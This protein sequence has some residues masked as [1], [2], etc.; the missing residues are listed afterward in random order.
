MNSDAAGTKALVSRLSAAKKAEDLFGAIAP[1]PT[2]ERLLA[3]KHLFASFVVLI[4]P[5][6]NP[7]LEDAGQHMARL[8]ALRMEADAL[9]REGTYGTHRKAVI[10]ATLR[11]P[12][13]V[14][15]VIDE[16]REGEVA[17]LFVAENAGK[18]CLLKVVREPGDNDLLDVEART[19]TELHRSADAKAPV[20]RKY[21]P[22]LLDSFVIIEGGRVR[23]RVNVLD[24]AEPQVEYLRIHK[25]KKGIDAPTAYYSLAEIRDAYP[26]GIDTR[27][28]AWMLRR[29][30]EGIGWVHSVG[31]VHGAMLPEH[32]LVHPLEH[33]GRLIDWTCAVRAGQR[34]TTISTTHKALYPAGVFRREPAT[35]ALDVQLIGTCG[36]LLL[37]DSSGALNADV[38]REMVTF[39]DA[40]VNGRVASGWDA[41]RT[42]DDVLQKLYGKRAYRAFEMPVV[43]GK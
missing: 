36:K 40:C 19:L 25:Q 30:F 29:V 35:P 1:G 31:Y 32:V 2:S 6:Q 27:D 11:S 18:R 22:Q 12:A 24:V 14:Y 16:F 15:K 13:G 7:N 10:D 43:R 39:L 8:V 38:P 21:L 34:L 28:A 20:F 5:D 9:L 42:F 23:R 3:V 17:D 37:S 33:G 41:Y 4:H 26:N